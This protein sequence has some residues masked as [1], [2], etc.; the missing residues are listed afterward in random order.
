MNDS[1]DINE[2]AEDII[3]KHIE[4]EGDKFDKNMKT[5][6]EVKNDLHEKV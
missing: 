4:D 5:V 3:S 1:K 2:M 6:K